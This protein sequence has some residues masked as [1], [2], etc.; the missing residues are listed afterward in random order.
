MDSYDYRRVL[1]RTPGFVFNSFKLC[2][3]LGLTQIQTMKDRWP[4]CRANSGGG[5]AATSET[6]R[7]QSASSKFCSRKPKK[8]GEPQKNIKSRETTAALSECEKKTNFPMSAIDF[9]WLVLFRDCHDT[10]GIIDA[11]AS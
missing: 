6:V 2:H 9:G 5:G 8:T 11:E 1:L 7:T 4:R 3:S 10:P